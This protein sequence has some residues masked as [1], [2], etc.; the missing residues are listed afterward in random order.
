MPLDLSGD[1]VRKIAILGIVLFVAIPFGGYYGV[2]YWGNGLAGVIV[3]SVLGVVITA[4]GMFFVSRTSRFFGLLAGERQAHFSERERLESDM[5][6]ARHHKIKKEYDVALRKVNAVLQTDPHY[7]E[8][9]FLK[10]Q[11]VLEGFE[12]EASAVSNLSRILEIVDDDTSTM[13]RW[14]E[15]L[16]EEIKQKKQS[17]VSF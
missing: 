1:A 16:L 12:N 5:Q 9:L 13:Y 15:S 10:A 2:M 4:C 14:A 6:Q 11:I 3:G 7:P 17:V 8:A